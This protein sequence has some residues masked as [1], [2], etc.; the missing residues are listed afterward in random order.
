MDANPYPSDHSW[1]KNRQLLAPSSEIVMG[2]SYFQIPRVE[3][4]HA[5]TYTLLANNRAGSGTFKFEL[6]VQ[7]IWYIFEVKYYSFFLHRFQ[8]R[9]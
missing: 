6:K 7:G 4:S 3:L 8:W 1:Y 5:G 9:L 2:I